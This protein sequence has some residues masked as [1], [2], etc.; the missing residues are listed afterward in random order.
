MVLPFVRA[1][2]RG[3]DEVRRLQ[4]AGVQFAGDIASYDWGRIAAFK[5]SEGNDLQLYAPRPTDAVAWR[6]V[7]PTA[8]HAERSATH[9]GPTDRP[10]HYAA[11]RDR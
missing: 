7:A 4:E 6:A 9:E 5:D 10:A 2:V 11:A 1:A 8:R 3:E